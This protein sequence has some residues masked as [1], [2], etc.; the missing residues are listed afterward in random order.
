M[1]LPF[2]NE[3]HLYIAIKDADADTREAPWYGPWDIVLR[4]YIFALFCGPPYLTITYPQFPVSKHIDTYYP[5]DDNVQ[6]DE[7]SDDNGSHV[8]MTRSPS[9]S[10][11]ATPQHNRTA[12]IRSAAPS[13]EVLR[14]SPS[15]RL[16]TPPRLPTMSRKIRS[17]RIPDF[18]QL[19]YKVKINPDDTLD[20]YVKR[21]M[22][23]VEIKRCADIPSAASF[24]AILPQLYLMF[25]KSLTTNNREV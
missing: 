20:K 4:N 2:S 13:P 24:V 8:Q 19:L 3:W 15:E 5:E 12:P 23:L 16:H 11:Y 7:D 22:L 9:V 14:G 18:V 25:R 21:I 1:A 17:T 6:D 10:P